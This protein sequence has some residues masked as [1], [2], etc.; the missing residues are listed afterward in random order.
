M[1]SVARTRTTPLRAALITGPGR[2]HRTF[3]HW[4]RGDDDPSIPTIGYSHQIYEVVD[5]CGGA[6]LTMYTAEDEK[7]AASHGR[8]EFRKFQ[9]NSAKGAAYHV[10]EVVTL[11][12]QIR[13]ARRFKADII[14]CQRMTPHFWVLS[15]ARALG[16]QIVISLHNTFWPMDCTPDRRQRALNEINGIFWRTCVAG[17]LCVSPEISRQVESISHK[18]A[19]RVFTHAPQYPDTAKCQPKL[20]HRSSD[21]TFG[22]AYLGR[23]ERNKGIFL[24]LEA[25][26]NLIEHTPNAQLTF[27]GG[28]SGLQSLRERAEKSAASESIRVLGQIKGEEVFDFI[29]QNDVLVCPTTTGFAE[30]LAK[31][32][33]E[34]ALCGVPS[35]I[36]D[37]VPAAEILG[38]ACRRVRADSVEDLSK[39]LRELSSSPET[40]MEMREA[41]LALRS[42][43]VDRSKSSASLLAEIV[44]ETFGKSGQ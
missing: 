21:A 2:V 20:P 9:R 12:R 15:I 41:G 25:F 35:I 33:I 39:A 44:H 37:V 6:L 17:T 22:V 43:F 30:G 10:H 28:G 18:H 14:I 1:A 11:L 32:P 8:F 4:S 38:A 23:V 29:V 19:R 36:S 31:T 3:L 42:T 13:A 7:D 24:V 40:L 27:A 16:I 34:A 26:E 5:A